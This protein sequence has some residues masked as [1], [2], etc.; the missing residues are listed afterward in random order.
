M[1]RREAF[2]AALLV[3]LALVAAELLTG[4]TTLRLLV[5]LLVIIP[6]TMIGG[7][8]LTGKGSM[9]VA[10]L[11]TASPE[12][13]AKINVEAVTRATGVIVIVSSVMIYL[14]FK[15]MEYFWVT[16]IGFIAFVVAALIYVNTAERFK[17]RPGDPEQKEFKPMSR[18]AVAAVA[19]SVF[20]LLGV[21]I[22]F[23]FTGSVNVSLGDTHLSVESTMVSE[24]IAYSDITTVE[25]I[26]DFSAGQ[27]VMGFGGFSISSGT[28][29]NDLFGEYTLAKYN[30]VGKVVAVHHSGGVL[31][32]NQDSDAAT[33]AVCDQLM[34]KLP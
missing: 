33:L 11:N 29:S 20:A 30:G 17:R 24:N 34:A 10:G 2:S 3:S 6:L 19:V 25:I 18:K 9:M 22:L 13:V 14:F 26:D 31:V 16:L 28:F 1:E 12:E 7:Y 8:L 21:L 15:V 5:L 32:F 23:S 4:Y 27:R